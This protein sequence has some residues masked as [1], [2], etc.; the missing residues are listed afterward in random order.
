MKVGSTGHL[1]YSSV[2]V[3]NSGFILVHG[4]TDMKVGST[5]HLDYSS[6]KVTN[7]GFIPSRGGTDMKVGINRAL[8]L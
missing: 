6:V 4:G 8:R 2:K 3:T 1:D 7:S 5:G